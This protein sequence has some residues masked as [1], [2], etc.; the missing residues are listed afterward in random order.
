LASVHTLRSTNKSVNSLESVS[1]LELDLGNR[2][3][4]AR[5]VD[6]VLDNALD[7]SMALSEILA[8]VSH[9]SLTE[10]GVSSVDRALSLAARLDDLSHGC[11]RVLLGTAQAQAEAEPH[12]ENRGTG[13][14]ENR[15]IGGWE[16][17]RTGGWENRRIGEPENGR[18]GEPEDGR[19]GGWEDGRMGE[20]EDRRMGEPEDGRTGEPENRRTG[21]PE[22]RRTGGSDGRTGILCFYEFWIEKHVFLQII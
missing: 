2:S 8:L 13:E 3:T 20:P 4:S 18:K 9:S 5:V 1:I 11:D 15:R 21:E 12:S 17:G 6:D 16:D 19:T 7:I 22:N 14:P 10:S